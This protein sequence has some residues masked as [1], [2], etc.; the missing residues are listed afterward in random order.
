M[1]KNERSLHVWL[2]PDIDIT[3]TETFIKAADQ[4]FPSNQLGQP[5]IVMR[6]KKSGLISEYVK[7]NETIIT[8]ELKPNFWRPLTDNDERGWRVQQLIPVV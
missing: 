5:C 4:S 2:I 3:L 8:S 7:G 1:I 6:Y